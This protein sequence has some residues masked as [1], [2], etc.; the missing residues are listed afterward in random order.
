MSIENENWKGTKQHLKFPFSFP[1]IANNIQEE[2]AL[3][4][5]YQ[6]SNKA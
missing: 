4:H 3:Y 2:G 5:E 6:T 1:L